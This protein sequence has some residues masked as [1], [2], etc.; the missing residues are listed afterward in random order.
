MQFLIYLSLCILTPAY[1]RGDSLVLRVGET[2]R[3]K[4]SPHA[5]VHVSTQSI[6]KVRDASP[7]LLIYANKAGSA[8]LTFAQNIYEVQ[9]LDNKTW[10][11]YQKLKL[12]T[13]SMIGLEVNVRNGEIFL[14]GRLLRFSDWQYIAKVMSSCQQ[15]YFMAAESDEDVRY[16]LMNELRKIHQGHQWPAPQ[17]TWA[18]KVFVD[19]HTELK[20]KENEFLAVYGPLGISLKFTASRLFVAPLV[21]VRVFLA[22]V[23][24]TSQT[25]F[26]VQWPDNYSA[27]LM[28]GKIT[29]EQLELTLKALEQKGVAHVLASP[30]LLCRSGGQAEFLAG[31][32]FP[33]RVVGYRSRE[34]T[35]KKHGVMLTIKPQADS[36]GQISLE[37]NSEISLVDTSQNIEGLP[38]LK[39]NRIS[40]HFDLSESRTVALSGLIREIDGHSRGGLPGLSQIPILGRLFSSE[41]YLN[42][43]SELVIFVTPEIVKQESTTDLAKPDPNPPYFPKMWNHDSLD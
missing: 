4:S 40:S 2:H 9:V 5:E 10:Q 19:L 28:S 8:T 24:K 1:A 35:W 33:I 31:G 25:V 26:G 15:G 43:R 38:A 13:K 21:K 27:Q 20:T 32:E 3:L 30:V 34:V 11:S 17:L 29:A 23:S 42:N 36:Q 14:E 41:E 16:D 39:T 6:I 7:D 12:V 37:I 18:D 22:E